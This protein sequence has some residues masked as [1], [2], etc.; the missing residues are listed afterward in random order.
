MGHTRA[1]QAAREGAY[2]GQTMAFGVA[3]KLSQLLFLLLAAHG[4]KRP[5]VSC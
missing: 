3:F 4:A 1:L 2:G 5:L